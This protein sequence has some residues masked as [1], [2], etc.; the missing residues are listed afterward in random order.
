M[1]YGLDDK[2]GFFPMLLYGIQWWIVSIPCV[3]IIGAVVSGVHYADAD[4]QTLY[5]QKLFAIMGVTTVVQVLWGHRLPLVVGPSSVLLIGV[6]GTLSSGI[7]AMYTAVALGGA[8]LVLVSLCGLAGKLNR[9]FTPRIVAVVLIL[10]ALTLSPVIL[11]LAIQNTTRPLQNLFFCIGLVFVLIVANKFLRGVAKAT[12][13]LWAI[14]VGWGVYALL[15]DGALT[16][17]RAASMTE[18][19]AS[20]LIP[21]LVFDP[22]VILSFFFCFVALAINELGS[23]EAVAHV[24]KADSLKRRTRNGVAVLGVANVA[25]GAVGVIGSV[26]FSMSTGVIAATRCASRYT[27]VPAGILLAVCAFLPD[28][29]RVLVAIPSPVMG[30]LLLYLMASQLGSSL[31][32][33]VSEK[34]VRGFSSSLI[35]AVPIMLALLVAYIPAQVFA[36]SLPL[37]RPVI[38]NA[39]VIGCLC[40]L[41]LEHVVFRNLTETDA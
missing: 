18:Q 9:V 16:P 1:D 30:S 26:D 14:L 6:M 21:S 8:L 27:L 29:I 32:M 35:I 17:E 24:L 33:V 36:G 39:F 37:L 23:I 7:S 38:G 28:V 41:V 34:L 3:V 2:P 19:S 5:V 4:A 20:F 22:G 12:L 11:N 15:P 31:T 13:L 10:V 25:S 40:V